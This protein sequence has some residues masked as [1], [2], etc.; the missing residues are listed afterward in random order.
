M[1]QLVHL[2]PANVYRYCVFHGLLSHQDEVAAAPGAGELPAQGVVAVAG[3]KVAHRVGEHA[4]QE[5]HLSLE[6]GPEMAPE[7]RAVSLQ[8]HLPTT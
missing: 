1:V 5:G 2:A 3:D 6:G 8:D 4:G 7:T